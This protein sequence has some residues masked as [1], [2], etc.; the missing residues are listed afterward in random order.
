M[1]SIGW[2]ERAALLSGAI[3]FIAAGVVMLFYELARLQS[4]AR[5][6]RHYLAAYFAF[7]VLGAACTM[8][9]IL[10]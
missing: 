4:R 8:L 10:K 5:A 9:A 2:L 3:V 7:F 6:N 1:E